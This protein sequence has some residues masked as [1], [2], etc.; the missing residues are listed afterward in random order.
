MNL[1][2]NAETTVVIELYTTWHKILDAI[3]ECNVPVLIRAILQLVFY[4]M[5][6]VMP[7]TL[8]KMSILH[9]TD[10]TSDIKMI[11]A[12]M[13]WIS[14][15]FY[16]MIVQYSM[17]CVWFYQSSSG[18]NGGNLYIS[19]INR[20]KIDETMT[21]VIIFIILLNMIVFF[22]PRI[23]SVTLMYIMGLTTVLNILTYVYYGTD[24]CFEYIDFFYI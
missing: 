21:S 7:G 20:T 24:D 15:I 22:T 10:Q 3:I 2:S 5:I 8:I 16:M 4:S 12:I 19:D 14:Y 9:V 11:L 18:Y 6:C 23:L 17:S 13:L 1:I